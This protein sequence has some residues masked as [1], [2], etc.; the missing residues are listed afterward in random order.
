MTL[1]FIRDMSLISSTTFYGSFMI[2]KRKEGRVLTALPINDLRYLWEAP[3][4]AACMS[5]SFTQSRP[6]LCLLRA[7][8]QGRCSA[9]LFS[10]L[11]PLSLAATSAQ[12]PQGTVPKGTFHPTSSSLPAW[13]VFLPQRPGP[14]LSCMPGITSLYAPK[15]TPPSEATAQLLFQKRSFL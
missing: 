6:E 5:I 11:P 8:S 10:S 3:V 14:R 7:R 9:S 15:F 1:I 12:Y 2:K 4:Q 13:P